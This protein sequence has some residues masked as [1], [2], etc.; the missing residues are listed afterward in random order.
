MLTLFSVPK[1]FSGQ[2]A[3]AQDN[4][5][6][7]WARLPD[8]ELILFGDDPGVADAAR[9][10]G[11]RHVDG[12]QRNHHGTPILSDVFSRADAM[13]SKP[14]LCFVNADIILFDDLIAATRIACAKRQD[15]LMVSSRFNC[16]IAEPL[17]F[18][19]QWD[20]ELRARSLAERH[21][22]PA[23]GSDIF[24][25]RPGLFGAVPPFAIGRGYWDN[26][27]MF[28]ARRRGATLI[29]A[30]E[31]VVAVHQHHDY[32]QIVGVPKGA[33]Q[34]DPL[35]LASEEAQQNLAL[36][37]GQARLLTVY[38]A[39]EILTRDDRLVSTLHPMLLRRRAKAWLRR[40][41]AAWTPGAL[42]LLRR[43]TA[44]IRR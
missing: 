44:A 16:R 38:D 25:Y 17:R 21:M 10:H 22:Y 36:A 14:I 15:F 2:A 30:T 31:R 32:F 1:E 40:R 41:M 37:G 8:C 43:W 29:D 19:P 12:V 20:R 34:S 23:A 5:I 11:A 13:A 35:Y 39:N 28:D 6:A 42:R 24:V 7:S 18:A 26:W 4:A 3:I 27:L 33:E 9:R